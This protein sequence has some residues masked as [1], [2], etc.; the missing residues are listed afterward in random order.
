MYPV[1]VRRIIIQGK[2]G[3]NNRREGLN[4]GLWKI[5]ESTIPGIMLIKKAASETYW[6]QRGQSG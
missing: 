3:T 1:K 4:V 6:A 5:T 2:I